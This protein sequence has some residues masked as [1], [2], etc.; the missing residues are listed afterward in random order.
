MELANRQV[1]VTGASGFIGGRLAER[2]AA[3]EGANVRV[4]V[5]RGG[6]D[7]AGATSLYSG[8]MTDASAVR[9]AVQGCDV[10]VHCAAKQFPPGT[11]T[12][13]IAEN[14]SGLR[15]LAEAALAAGVERFV[16]LSTINVHGYPPPRGCNA[17][18]P[19][20]ESGDPYSDSKVAT[21]RL[22]W[23]YYREQ[24]LP[25]VVVRPACTYG[26]R[27]GAWTLTPLKRVR[28][29]KRVLVGDGSGLCN[30][31]YIDNLVDLILLATKNDAALGQ[32]FIGSDGIGVPWREFYGA[33][34]RMLGMSRL[35]A[36][37]LTAA[38]AIATVSE[39][40]APATGGR[41]LVARQSVEFYSHHVVYDIANARAVLG[42]APRVSF[43]EGMRRTERWL[44]ETGAL[45]APHVGR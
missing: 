35:N 10:V 25:L 39:Y 3:E 19:L 30:T 9:R 24:H 33:Y 14:T 38:R 7:I 34:A 2:L 11:R 20:V 15:N 6:A 26:P 45:Q 28:A 16:H 32:A 18:S 12:Q 44:V 23:K 13:F 40:L 8:D 4:L 31:A 43:Q 37:P 21:E 1:L 5:R 41:P 22:A 29:A 17:G 36:V 42:Y 27:G